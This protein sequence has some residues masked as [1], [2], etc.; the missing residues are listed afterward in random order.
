VL[1]AS[2]CRSLLASR[3]VS[4]IGFVADDLHILPITHA[5][6]GDDVAFKSA[7]GTK[8]GKAAAG[9]RVVIQAD[10]TDDD[11]QTGWSVLARGR[12]RIVTDDDELAEL[13]MLPFKPWANVADD[14]LWV[15]VE[16]DEW[17]G[18]RVEKA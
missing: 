17:T 5:V 14:G 13:M 9:G 15:R 4:R 10:A 2:T 11:G 12:A 7:P 16:V 8:L 6:V 1:D 18:R 3:G